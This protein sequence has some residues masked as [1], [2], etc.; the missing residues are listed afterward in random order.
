MIQKKI[1]HI[2]YAGVLTQQGYNKLVDQWSLGV[3]LYEF[4]AGYF[5][6][7]EAKYKIDIKIYK[8]KLEQDA[9]ISDIAFDL[10]KKFS[11]FDP[12]KKI[13]KH[14]ED[15]KNHEFFKDINLLGLEKKKLHL[16]INLKLDLQE[17]LVILILC[18]L[19][20]H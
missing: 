18:L 13:G 3:L 4:L 11:T 6:Y 8:K 10:I 15:I 5:P 17:M 14:V 16:L 2:Q 7:K 19:K 12:S 1:K 20:C 9:L